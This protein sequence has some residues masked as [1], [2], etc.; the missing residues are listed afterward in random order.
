[1]LLRRITDLENVLFAH[2]EDLIEL[3]LNVVL[4]KNIFSKCILP[5]GPMILILP[6]SMQIATFKFT[7]RPQTFYLTS[8]KCNYGDV[9]CIV[10][11]GNYV[12]NAGMYLHNAT[13]MTHLVHMISAHFS[14]R[15]AYYICDHL[16]AFVEIGE[17]HIQQ[18]EQS[19]TR[20]FP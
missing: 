8:Y 10:N 11:Y 12:L 20:R 9:W 4:L 16:V 1:M 17:L 14:D 7:L 13:G 3:I 18:R 6:I 2:L 15:K 19:L 5:I